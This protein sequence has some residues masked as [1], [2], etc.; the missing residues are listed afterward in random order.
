M[1]AGL[2][3]EGSLGGSVLCP[4]GAGGA[5]SP[6]QTDEMSHKTDLMEVL[7]LPVLLEK[8]QFSRVNKP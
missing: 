7:P 1:S 3:Y 2:V 5:S 4:G 8:S 6:E